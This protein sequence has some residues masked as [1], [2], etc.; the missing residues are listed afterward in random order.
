[1]F[2]RRRTF[3]RKGLFFGCQNDMVLLQASRGHCAKA[4]RAF[5]E[6]G[7]FPCILYRIVRPILRKSTEF[8]ICVNRCWALLSVSSAWACDCI[9][10]LP[11]ILMPLF[12][13]MRLIQACSCPVIVFFQVTWNPITAWNDIKPNAAHLNVLKSCCSSPGLPGTAFKERFGCNNSLNRQYNDSVSV[14]T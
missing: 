13:F 10:W 2:E 12:I 9:V 3:K 7:S 6:K 14:C 1:M 11:L 8:G 4:R 5:S